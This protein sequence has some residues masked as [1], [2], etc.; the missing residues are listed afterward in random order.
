MCFAFHMTV[1]IKDVDAASG[2]V[3]ADFLK[4]WKKQQKKP[5]KQATK[6]KK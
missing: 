6:P 2:I 3:A 4:A 5:G 1:K